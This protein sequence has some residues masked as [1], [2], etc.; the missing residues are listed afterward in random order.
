M[1]VTTQEVDGDT[2]A[3]RAL[4]REHPTLDGAVREAVEKGGLSFLDAGH[5]AT[6][7]RLVGEAKAPVFA[8]QLVEELEGGLDKV[9]VFCEHKTPIAILAAELTRRGFK[10][11]IVHG[12]TLPT[13]RGPIVE[14]FQSDPECRVFIGSSAAY[15]GITL[16]AASQLVM[17]E[18]NWSP[19]KNAQA[20][21]RVHRIGQDRNVHVRFIALAKSIDADIAAT[22]ARKTSDIVAVQ[23]SEI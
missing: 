8:R 20:L 2:A 23:G 6:L 11:V 21:K 17:L 13:E 1:W 14:E 7:R 16:T 10:H 9:V 15:E 22:V 3:V 12:G 5:I 4:L 18:Q 19:A